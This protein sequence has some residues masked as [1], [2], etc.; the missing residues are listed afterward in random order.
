MKKTA[1]FLSA[2]FLTVS[3]VG[4][5]AWAAG[6]AEKGKKVAEQKCT[7][8]HTFGKAIA[9][10]GKV[11]PT[12]ENGI[13]GKPAGKVQGFSYSPGLQ[14]MSEG[15]L[16]WTE[17]N[18]DKFLTNPKGF[19]QGTKMM[20]FPGLPAEGERADVIAFLKTLPVP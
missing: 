3:I 10:A 8:C 1:L 20:A 9:K 19:I 15:G 7:T 6:D 13:V 17:E 5:S 18:L 4:S 12:L 16:T 14:K 11:G 2:A